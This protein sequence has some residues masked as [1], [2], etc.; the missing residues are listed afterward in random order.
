MELA[1]GMEADPNGAV[2]AAVL[3]ALALVAM[4]AL[5]PVPEVAFVLQAAGLGAL[6]GTG[7]ALVERRRRG[8]LDIGLR[9]AAGSVM[10]AVTG[11]LVV[12]LDGLLF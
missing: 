5:A 11:L 8:D 4:V 10:G 9:T 12:G 3:L 7:V 2:L 1:F 6:T